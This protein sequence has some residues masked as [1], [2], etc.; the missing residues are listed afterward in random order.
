M[1]IL[2]F[3]Y[4]FTIDRILDCFQVLVMQIMFWVFFFFFYE[5]SCTCVLECRCVKVRIHTPGSGIGELQNMHLP[6]TVKL[7]SFGFTHLRPH[8]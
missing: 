3:I 4:S 7:F 1:N 6:D 2:Q 5:F 8:Q